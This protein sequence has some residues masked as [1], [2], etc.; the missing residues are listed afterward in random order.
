MQI[1]PSANYRRA[2][3]YRED[4]LAD[5]DRHRLTKRWQGRPWPEMLMVLARRKAGT[6]L[7]YVGERLQGA[8]PA[9]PQVEMPDRPKTHTAV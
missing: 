2:K 4:L 9:L 3:L 1:D 7:V 6:V 5:A 8:S